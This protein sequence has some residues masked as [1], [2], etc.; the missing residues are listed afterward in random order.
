MLDSVTVK[1]EVYP[2]YVTTELP[3]ISSHRSSNLF[4]LCSSLRLSV[5]RSVSILTFRVISFGN[6]KYRKVL[7]S[8][9]DTAFSDQVSYGHWKANTAIQSLLSQLLR[10][11]KVHLGA[12]SE[13]VV[14]GI[15][16]STLG[17][18]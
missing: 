1:R 2:I 15:D 16:F 4:S 13:D 11:M 6:S 14:F 18:S 3:S 12:V 7:L 8:P 10:V 17:Y 9:M 5:N